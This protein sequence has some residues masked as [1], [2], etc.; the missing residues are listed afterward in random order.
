MGALGVFG[1]GND[2]GRAVLSALKALAPVTPEASEGVM[3]T[4]RQAEADRVPPVIGPPTLG[5]PGPRPGPP[6]T[7]MGAMPAPWPAVLSRGGV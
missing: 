3:K 7:P 4:E 6:G 1:V 5:V 2:E